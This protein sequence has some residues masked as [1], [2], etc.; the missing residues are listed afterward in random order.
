MATTDGYGERFGKRLDVPAP[1]F[2]A[3]KHRKS[4]VAV[5]QTRSDAPERRLTTATAIEDAFIVALQLR[6]FPVHELWVDGKAQPVTRLQAGCSSLYDLRLSQVF[7]INNPFHSVHFYFPREVIDAIADDAGAARIDELHFTLGVGHDDA[8][9]RSLA[10]AILPA[11]NQPEQAN[12]LFIEHVTLA[13]GT[14]VAESYGEMRTERRSRHGGLAP[15]QEKRAKEFLGA[16]LDGEVSLAELARECSLSASHFAR[17]FRQSTGTS[18]HQ[19][20]L[21][22]RVDR[23]MELLVEPRRSLTEVALACGFADQSHFTRVFTRSVGVS[24]GAWRRQRL[25]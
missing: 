23:A 10:T 11:F 15:W 14:H 1:V 24:P 16:R 18:P 22:R 4:V 9:V 6:D 13:V 3:Q 12:R 5:T 20:L 19:W 21:R 8:V 7:N 25:N 2:F 17:A